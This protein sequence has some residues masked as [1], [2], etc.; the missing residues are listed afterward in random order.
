MLAFSMLFEALRKNIRLIKEGQVSSTAGSELFL[1]ENALPRVMQSVSLTTKIFRECWQHHRW[2]SIYASYNACVG[3]NM[4]MLALG[5]YIVAVMFVDAVIYYFANRDDGECI[6]QGSA[7][8]CGALKNGFLTGSRKCEWDASNGGVSNTGYHREGFCT[9]VHPTTN[10]EVLLVVA[11][12]SGV[13]GALIASISSFI[14]TRVLCAPSMTASNASSSASAQK[15]ELTDK[16]Q[17]LSPAGNS[18]P[19]ALS[20]P[21]TPS[22]V[23]IRGDG[24]DLDE[25][26]MNSTVRA[27]YGWKG[28]TVEETAAIELAQMAKEL[29]KHRANEFSDKEESEETRKRLAEFDCEF[30]GSANSYAFTN[31]KLFAQTCGASRT[32]DNSR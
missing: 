1:I 4:R 19:L 10:Y 17:R 7:A 15:Y 28:Y 27:R 30:C 9:F 6:E 18:S 3:R 8:D 21:S 13:V 5:S 23:V 24:P 14:I 25:G 2:I 16:P 32:K 20:P 31:L 12:V 29:R 22:K 26:E 11:I